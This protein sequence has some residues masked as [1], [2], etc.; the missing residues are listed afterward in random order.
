MRTLHGSSPVVSFGPL[1]LKSVR[2]EMIRAANGRS[3]INRRVGRIVRMFKW[4]VSEE[5]IP[6]GIY[7]ALRTVA[8]L[9]KGRSQVKEKPPV[10]PVAEADFEA[11]RNHVSRQVWAMIE[12]QRRAGM[13]PVEVVIMRCV[14]LDEGG[15]IWIYTSSRHK[16]E[17]HDKVWEVFIG[18]KCQEILRPWLESRSGPYLFSP[19]EAIKERK[20]KRRVHRKTRVQPSQQDRSRKKPKKSPASCTDQRQLVFLPATKSQRPGLPDHML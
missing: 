15:D 2:N 18:P 4:G 7:E 12:L 16:T 17:H 6:A 9:R 3:K 20:E 5:L 19:S 14:D 11:V 1:A 8:G 13:R 10:G